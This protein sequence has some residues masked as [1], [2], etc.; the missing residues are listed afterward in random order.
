MLKQI[1][2]LKRR[3]GMT[4]EE[5]KDYY[6]NVHSKLGEKYM[7]LARRYFR[8]YVCPE[9]NPITR[10]VE[11][12][13][14]DVVM[15]IWWDSREDFESTMESIGSGEIHRLFVEDEKK[16]FDRHSNRVFTVEEKES[17]MD[18]SWEGC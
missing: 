6:E 12:L 8:R 9:P 14:F 13:D 16:I 18:R 5:F 11:E 1:V 4:M 7:P 2:L 3:P 15:E 17:V 10:Q